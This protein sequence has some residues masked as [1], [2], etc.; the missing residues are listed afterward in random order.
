MTIW[1]LLLHISFNMWEDEAGPGLPAEEQ[2]RASRDYLRC[3]DE[4]FAELTEKAAVAGA[5]MVVLD[6]G[7]GIEY[8]SHP[9][10]AVRGAWSTTRLREE[11]ARL[12]KLGL[13]PIPK[14]N[15]SACHDAWLGTYQR[16]VSTA[17]YY[18]TCADLISEVNTLFDGPRFF[19]LGMDE[20]TPEHQEHHQYVVVRQHDLWWHDLEF[21]CDEVRKAG[22][23][24]WVW[25][26]P[27]WR[28]VG[29]YYARM[30]KTVVQSNWYYGMGFGSASEQGRP[31]ALEGDERYLTYLDL[32]DHGFD[33]IPTGGN[34]FGHLNFSST[35][36]FCA[37][38]LQP[39]RLLGFLQ[40]P[41]RPTLPERR[42]H[43]LAAIEELSD[44]I[45]YSSRQI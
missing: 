7:D 29:T 2:Y 36:E 34:H 6:L 23:R 15:F 26:D 11:L 28:K 44:V 3:D 9:E 16:Q 41:W 38:R 25:A 37:K 43:H 1:G 22:S 8:T 12:R 4:L 33:Q 21:L 39:D 32:D 17:P 40:A 13:E 20:E 5:N 24:P 42:E 18:Q 19:H 35:V 30:Q 27:A 45:R 14:L 31:R 10:I